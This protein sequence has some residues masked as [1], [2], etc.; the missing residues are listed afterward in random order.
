MTNEFT[1]ISFCVS[2]IMRKK[3]NLVKKKTPKLIDTCLK[4][5]KKKKNL[6]QCTPFL[7]CRWRCRPIS[8]VVSRHSLPSRSRPIQFPSCSFC[9]FNSLRKKRKRQIRVFLSPKKD[10]AHK[11]C[12]PCPTR[13]G[14]V[15]PCLC[16]VRAISKSFDL[17]FGQRYTMWRIEHVSDMC[18]VHV[19][20]SACPTHGHSTR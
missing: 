1:K 16:R 6:A 2:L 17:L 18:S 13:V 12:P 15:Q 3:C 11:I 8:G 9:V 14:Q 10:K 5:K 7:R 20:V 4:K 19:H